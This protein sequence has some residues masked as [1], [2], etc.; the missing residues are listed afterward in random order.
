MISF[1]M[2]IHQHLIAMYAAVPG[3]SIVQVYINA[4]HAMELIEILIVYA[5]MDI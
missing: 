5:Q 2:E 4:Q 1:Q 3:V